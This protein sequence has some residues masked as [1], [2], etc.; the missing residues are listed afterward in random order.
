MR[1]IVNFSIPKAIITTNPFELSSPHEE[2][3]FLIKSI[4]KQSCNQEGRDYDLTLFGGSEE[5]G[6]KTALSLVKWTAGRSC[7]LALAG[8]QREALHRLQRVM[9]S[10]V[11]LSAVDARLSISVLLV[12]EDEEFEMS[13]VV[14]KSKVVVSASANNKPMLLR[15]CV[16]HGTHYCDASTD[17]DHVRKAISQYDPVAQQSGSVVIPFCSME[18]FHS[19]LSVY[20]CARALY[21]KGNALSEIDFIKTFSPRDLQSMVKQ[22]MAQRRRVLTDLDY[23]PLLRTPKGSKTIHKLILTSPAFVACD[24]QTKLYLTSPLASISSIS[25]GRSH[26]LHSAPLPH[27][28]NYRDAIAHKSFWGALEFVLESLAIRYIMYF[29]AQDTLHWIIEY[30]ELTSPPQTNANQEEDILVRGHGNL[31][32][33]V[34]FRLSFGRGGNEDIEATILAHTALALAASKFSP[35]VGGVLTPA[36]CMGNELIERLLRAGWKLI[37]EKR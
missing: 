36:S 17:L 25:V 13:T 23:D 20:L 32:Y 27:R 10:A 7:R 22:W 18:S 6:T 26:A 2:I 16:L 30:F 21:Q 9:L 1:E 35:R 37:W 33:E 24:E 28:L 34:R 8:S 4:R 5:F 19:D 14:E 12:D 31:G 15:C 29:F 11:A 3:D